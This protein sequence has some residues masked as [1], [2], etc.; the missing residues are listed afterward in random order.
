MGKGE[1]SGLRAFWGTEGRERMELIRYQIA[2]D[3]RAAPFA[4]ITLACITHW[5]P[6]QKTDAC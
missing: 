6:F 2:G 1:I 4:D 5:S 3:D